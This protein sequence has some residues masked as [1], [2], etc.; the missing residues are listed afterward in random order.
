MPLPPFRLERFF[1]RYEHSVEHLLCASDCE[2]WSV[3]ELLALE[4]GAR[5]A[6]L[7]LRLGY[8]ESAGG[9]ELRRE[10]AGLY[11]TVTPEDVLVFSGGQEAIYALMHAWLEPGDR[12]FVH[13]PSY[14]SLHE[15]AREI[16][17]EVVL[18]RSR[19]ED[20]WALDPAFL[21]W[22]LLRRGEGRS[23]A[24]V[25]N[26]PHNPTGYVMGRHE[27]Q[28]LVVLARDEG[29]VLVSDEVYRLLEYRDEDR[30]PAACDL[31]DTAV[32]LGVLSKSFGLPGL[33]IGWVATRNR[34]LLERL[35]A[36]KDYLTICS[37]APSEHLAT[38]ALRHRETLVGRNREIVTSNLQLL[39]GFMDRRR[40]VF[41]WVPPTAGPLAYPALVGGEGANA[42]CNRVLEASGVLLLPGSLFDDCDHRHV[43]IGFGRKSFAAG[44]ARLD[45]ALDRR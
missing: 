6:F 34:P 23:R 31:D 26:C 10:I 22:Q 19:E 3:A 2:S 38:L 7:D 41:E 18:W 36:F 25:L 43:R 24:V 32:S 4:P 17:C 8:T 14:P 40:D 1:A 27:L 15:V 20:G 9:L 33:R 11:E 28:D 13:F 42:F 37:S 29:L 45:E 12:L 44:L 16:G 35:A 30:L 5:E 21:R 39:E